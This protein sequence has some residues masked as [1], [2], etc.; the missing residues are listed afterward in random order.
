MGP[1]KKNDGSRAYHVPRPGG[2]TEC[3]FFSAGRKN[4]KDERETIAQGETVHEP[5][6][7][8]SVDSAPAAA[9]HYS[10]LPTLYTF[11]SA[12]PRMF[13]FSSFSFLSLARL[14]SRVTLFSAEREQN[15][16]HDTKPTQLSNQGERERE[17]ERDSSV[18]LQVL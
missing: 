10:F 14:L 18:L 3:C 9:R 5:A 15:G 2:E 13:L 16:R 12:V 11:L 6:R 4:R 7:G 17:G 1:K 8:S